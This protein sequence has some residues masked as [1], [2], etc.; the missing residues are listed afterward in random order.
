[1]SIL[2]ITRSAVLS[3]LL[4][5]AATPVAVSTAA[6]DDTNRPVI[7]KKDDLPRHTYQLDTT[8]TAL[9]EDANRDALIALAEAVAADIRNDLSRFDIRDDNTVQAFYAV[10]GADAALRGDW[11]DYLEYLDR[12]RR[13]ETKRA[14]QLT[15]GLAGEAISRAAVDGRHDPEAIAAQLRARVETLPYAEAEANLK[16]LKGSTEILSRSLVLGS[17]ASRYQPVIDRTAGEISY[18]VASALVGASFT[19]EHFVP[20]APAMSR[21]LA[22]IIAAN[23]T[24]KADIWEERRITL[25]ADA[26]ASPVIIAVWDSGAD[27]ALFDA[28]GQLWVNSGEVPGN[29]KDDDGN[30]YVDDVHGIAFDLE[31]YRVSEPLYPIGDVGDEERMQRRVKGLGDIQYNVDSPEAA[32]VREQLASLPQAEVQEFLESLGAYSGYAHGTHVAGIALE[33]NPFARLLTARM[34][35]PYTLLPEKPTLEQ[36]HRDAAMMRDTIAY[37]QA[38]GV[39]AVNMSWGGSLR[40]I[41]SAL[42]AHNV[43]ETP[44]A[45]KA[46][47][48]D[49]YSINDTALRE[50]IQ[51][52]SDILFIISAGNSDN[53]IRF[54]EYFPSSYD[55]PNVLTVGA[56]DSAGDETSF[57]SLGKVDIYANGHEVE[58]YVPGGNRIA[59]SGTSMSSPQVTNLAGKLLALAPDLGMGEL[60]DLILA[61]GEEKDLGE[62]RI[63]LMDPR[64]S[65]QLL[66]ASR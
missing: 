24:D 29:G 65:R 26:T 34:T 15:M 43:G 10:L 39:R 6:S 27:T 53:D 49:I 5:I 9:Y 3:G 50:A 40:M 36:A 25:A 21:V 57:T 51:D 14:N 63:L 13:L 58:S 18:D 35:Y 66:E 19:L 2:F 54:D 8:V 23:S 12:R 4:T 48:R 64:A 45:R 37:F 59:F 16:S 32:E 47:A 28:S 46:L 30:G 60:R 33:G 41:E 11:T 22:E 17:L 42:E 55:Y 20:A 7:T 61:G 1:M 44:E 52:A 56:V 31:G 62:R 38:N